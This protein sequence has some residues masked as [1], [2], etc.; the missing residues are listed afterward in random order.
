MLGAY[1]CA[2]RFPIVGDATAV[3]PISKAQVSRLYASVVDY[4]AC[5]VQSG[6]SVAPLADRAEFERL[7]PAVGGL[8]QPPPGTTSAVAWQPLTRECTEP[9]PR[10]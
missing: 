10:P 3:S 2:I 6:E 4:G 1:V 8:P 7:W 9:D 5:V